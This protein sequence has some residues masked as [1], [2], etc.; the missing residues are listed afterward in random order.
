MLA[1]SKYLINFYKKIQIA[2][3]F[4]EH[5]KNMWDKQDYN[6]DRFWDHAQ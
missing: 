5:N 6:I 2:K 1:F 3:I 4:E